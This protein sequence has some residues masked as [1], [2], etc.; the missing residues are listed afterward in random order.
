[1]AAGYGEGF[2]AAA[3]LDD[4]VAVA[5][6][7]C[8]RK[9]ADGVFVFDEEYG[10]CS[11]QGVGAR[12]AGLVGQVLT[13]EVGGDGGSFAEGAFGGDVSVALLYDAVDGG[14][15]EAGAVLPVPGGVEGFEHA[16][17]GGFVHA[18]AGVAH[19]EGDV[20]AGGDFVRAGG[21]RLSE[22]GV[23]G[24]EGEFSAFGHGLAGVDGEVDDD[25]LDLDGIGVDGAQFIG[26]AEVEADILAEETGQ[27]PDHVFEEEV[28][29]EVSGLKYAAAA[30]GEQLRGEGGGAFCGLADF[31]EVGICGVVGADAAQGDF[32]VAGDGGE[33]VV[34]VVGNTAGES[35]DGFHF[36][37]VA[38]LGLEEFLLG[39]V[40]D[41]VDD[42]F[43]LPH[44]P[45]HGIGVNVEIPAVRVG[46]VHFD[47]GWFALCEGGG[48][49]A[50]DEGG[51]GGF[52]DVVIGAADNF[53]TARCFAKGA[54]GVDD[55]VVAVED[56]NHVGDRVKGCPPTLDAVFELC[57]EVAA[58]GDVF[59]LGDDEGVVCVGDDVQ[60]C[61][62]GD[63]FS[64]FGLAVEYGAAD[65][66]S[67]LETGFEL[68]V[69]FGERPQAEV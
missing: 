62:E 36:R 11:A 60:S 2:D 67:G 61:E 1:M 17:E 15:S 50:V 26:G 30:E 38:E 46:F 64:G 9:F 21:A 18:G 51:E 59:C 54:V 53:P 32:A 33:E 20:A 12:V 49:G 48:G 23:G 3:G 8:G 41:D 69:F 44:F 57:G 16:C 63:D 65:R 10:F 47:V 19:D 29:V 7:D 27:D 39:D 68:C 22:V 58:A 31:G 42:V 28:E 35:A 56:D 4:V 55:S 14:E 43:H 34:E 40:A 5:A 37:G 25:L 52:R 6:Q 13:G 24:G 66:I 45:A